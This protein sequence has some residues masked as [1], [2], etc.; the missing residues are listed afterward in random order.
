MNIC[1]Q[2]VSQLKRRLGVDAHTLVSGA[3]YIGLSN[4]KLKSTLKHHQLIACPGPRVLG[5]VLGV[6]VSFS[7]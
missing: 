6:G 4:R 1:A 2:I 5:S 3:Q 7:N